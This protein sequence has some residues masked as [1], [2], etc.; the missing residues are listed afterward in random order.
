MT[1][2]LIPADGGEASVEC[3]V[4]LLFWRRVFHIL[5]VRGTQQVVQKKGG[6]KKEVAALR[7][8]PAKE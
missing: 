5:M 1:T 7:R 6:R 4:V 3:L 8:Y 2:I